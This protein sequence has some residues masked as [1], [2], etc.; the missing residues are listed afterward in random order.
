MVLESCCSIAER[1]SEWGQLYG[2]WLGV[3]LTEWAGKMVLEDLISQLRLTAQVRPGKEKVSGSGNQQG[4]VLKVA[5]SKACRRY[6]ASGAG[7][8]QLGVT[9]G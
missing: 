9:G 4:Q 8:D 3:T 5:T 6:E 1:I 2:E 7:M